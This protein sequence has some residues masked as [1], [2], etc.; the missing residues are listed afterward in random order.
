MVARRAELWVRVGQ[1]A[2]TGAGGAAASSDGGSRPRC[3][4]C[5][6]RCSSW[7]RRGPGP[8]ASERVGPQRAANCGRRQGDSTACWPPIRP[9]PASTSRP[10]RTSTPPTAV[11]GRRRRRRAVGQEVQATTGMPAPQPE[12]YH[13]SGVE[14]LGVRRTARVAR[15]LT[16]SSRRCRRPSA[17]TRPRSRR[18]PA[19]VA[20]AAAAAVAA[21]AAAAEE[22][23]DRGEIPVDRGVL[24]PWPC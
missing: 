3:W 20:A 13:S 10:A 22:E 4:G 6:S 2:G 9:R 23:V 19:A 8:T 21:V 7:S 24:S 14:R 16:V 17:P 18:R 11:R 1:R 5:R 15:A 12:W